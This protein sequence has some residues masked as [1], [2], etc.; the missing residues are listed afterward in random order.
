MKA[1]VGRAITKTKSAK[2]QVIKN[3]LLVNRCL[4]R[5][6][7]SESNSAPQKVAVAHEAVVAAMRA[8]SGVQQQHG[9][10]RAATVRMARM[11]QLSSTVTQPLELLV[12]KSNV[13]MGLSLILC[14]L[15]AP[16]VMEVRGVDPNTEW[17]RRTTEGA[18][19]T[20]DRTI[21]GQRASRA[22]PIHYQLV[23]DIN[24][25]LV[26]SEEDSHF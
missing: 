5:P 26:F 24:N 17:Y 12:Q 1:N 25:R 19:A 11:S 22:F 23:Q 10:Q 7:R 21:L 14:V 13:K 6:K 2:H 3:K 4:S 8:I 9:Q 16:S 20:I 18:G 15:K